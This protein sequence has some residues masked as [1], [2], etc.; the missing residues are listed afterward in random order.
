MTDRFQRPASGGRRA[1]LSSGLGAGAL[2]AL[3]RPARS[4][5][6]YDPGASDAE[7]RIGNTIPYSGP[8][9]NY[10]TMARTHA[11]WF[12]KVNDEG[13]IGGRR[14]AYLSVDDG[15]APPRTV[16]MTRKLVESDEV[17]FMFGQLGTATNAAIQ[18]YLNSRGV[19]H[20]FLSTGASRFIDPKGSPWSMASLPGYQ[21]E[22]RVYAGHVL[23]TQPDAPIAILSQNDDYGREFVRGFRDGLGERVK[24]IVAEVTCEATDPT[25]DSQVLALKASDAKVFFNVTLAKAASQA[26][27]KAAD[28]GWRPTQYVIGT[29]SGISSTLSPAGLDR[30]VGILTASYAKD[31]RDPR[32][33]D[34]AGMRDYLAFMKKYYPEG[35]ALDRINVAG[36]QAAQAMTDAL[37]RCGDQL[38]RENVMKQVA[39]FR[40]LAL[41]TLLPGIRVNTT[42]GDY[43]VIRSMQIERFDGARYV[44][45]GDLVNL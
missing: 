9:S 38:T 35:D 20:L 16:E 7:I 22:G 21:T 39:S 3:P 6:K 32:W 1:A 30:S 41:P 45:I 15:Y 19:P 5:K 12:R 28:V 17:L 36:Y 8:A 37:R 42:P 40:D 43:R 33:A 25:V 26:I 34:D 11:A 13:G 18:K 31:P 14:I 2:L 23:K 4:Q 44:P 24:N 29:S 27:R 10:G